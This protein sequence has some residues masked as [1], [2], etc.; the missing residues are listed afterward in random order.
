MFFIKPPAV[1]IIKTERLI[2]RGIQKQDAGD[3][4]KYCADPASSKYA[5]WYPHESIL[6]TKTYIAWQARE[7]RRGGFMLWAIEMKNGGQVIGTCSLTR[8]KDNAKIAELGYGIRKEFQKNGYAS[9]A[10]SA[11]LN[12]AFCECGATRIFARVMA[13]NEPSA[14]LAKRVGMTLEGKLKKGIFCKGKSYDILLF[15]ETD[16]EFFKKEKQQ[17]EEEQG[18]TQ[19]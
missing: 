14:R 11:A 15:A 4:F 7:I 17:A 5:V 1:P 16:D 12:Y 9:E 6:E 2:L 8:D 10:V 18:A 3:I 13:E 19:V